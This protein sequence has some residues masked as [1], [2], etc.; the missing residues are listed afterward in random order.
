MANTP[1]FNASFG[2]RIFAI[3]SGG[4]LQFP[5]GGIASYIM[6]IPPIPPIPPIIPPI[7]PIPPM[8]SIGIAALWLWLRLI[9]DHGSNCDQKAGNGSGIYQST[10][11]HKYGIDH[12]FFEKIAESI[13]Q[14]IISPSSFFFKNFF[15]D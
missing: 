3:P 12:A 11:G 15:S 1:F 9:S 7:P 13:G 4:F 8:P 14:S 5:L 6:S 10:L 2:T